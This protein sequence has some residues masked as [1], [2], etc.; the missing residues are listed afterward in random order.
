MVNKLTIL[1]LLFSVICF[2]QEEKRSI[3]K[4]Q[5]SVKMAIQE[6]KTGQLKD[7]YNRYVPFIVIDAREKRFKNG[8][9][10]PKSLSLSVKSSDAEIAKALKD[11]E[12]KLVV[13]SSNAICQASTKL[14]KRLM[15]LG[16][17][18]VFEY[19]AGIMAW[20]KVN[21][22]LIREK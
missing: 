15:G 11:K 1:M 21:N 4:K 8:Y 3:L 10:L 19:K 22:N 17:K 5:P 6:I 18:N 2:G 12:I 16:Y 9:R 20:R 7:M 14:V 13:Y